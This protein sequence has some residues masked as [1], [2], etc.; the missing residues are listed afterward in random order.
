MAEWIKKTIGDVFDEVAEKYPR[1][2]AFIFEDKRFTY[3]DMQ[4]RV[5]A[6]AKGLLE[7]GVQKQD[8]VSLWMS[9]RPEWMIA[10]FAISKIGAILVPI[11]TRYKT[12]ELEYILKQSHS[13]TL[14]MMDQFLNISYLDMIKEACPE[15]ENSVSG[16]LKSSKLPKLKN[17]VLLGKETPRGS[18]EF[19]QVMENGAKSNLDEDLRRIQSSIDPEDI[20]NIQYTSGTTGFPKGAMLSH[21]MYGHMLSV[22]NG[23]KFT[24]KDCLMIP[25]P[26]FH[27]FGSI[28]GILL[29]VAQGGTI[30]TIEYFEPEACLKMIDRAKATA[31]HGVPTMFLMQMEHP[32][33]KKYDVSSLRTGVIG[34]TSCPVEL[35]KRIIKEMHLPELTVV[36]GI[37]ETSSCTTQSAIGDSPEIVATTVG[38]PL[39]FLEAKLVDPQSGEEVAQGQ[40][41][42]FCARGPMVMKGYYKMPEET[43]KAIDTEGWFHTGDLLVKLKD[44]NYKVTGRVK[45][46]YLVGGENTYPVEIENFL[47]SHPK[48]KQIYVVGVPDQRLGEVGMAFIELKKGE[49]STEEE[50]IQYCKGKIANYKIP[51]YVEFVNEFPMTASGKTQKFKLQE[52]GTQ[53]RHLG[54]VD[55]D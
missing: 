30:A 31:I 51:R 26:F 13:G 42:E 47:S 37:T 55:E 3:Q 48:I 53:A 4:E 54:S 43:K 39:P 38:K 12:H 50:I 1:K 5:I 41:G 25:N 33:F 29:A 21:N 40:Q 15:L 7:I 49:S 36:Y 18:F 17:L 16:K 24:S 20:V 8:K 6:F 28:C 14:I 11:N 27:V 22:G 10:K 34:G 19:Y 9:N 44:D 2:T 52:I 35:L 45:E 32:D 46:M 23:M